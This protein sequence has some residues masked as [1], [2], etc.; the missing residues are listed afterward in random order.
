MRRL[1]RLTEDQIKHEAKL[2]NILHLI[3]DFYDL[4]DILNRQCYM[5]KRAATS[6]SWRAE[7]PTP[8]DRRP[9][10][11]RL[12]A[13]ATGSPSTT[14]VTHSTPCILHTCF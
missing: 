10:R 1:A 11:V 4:L 9:V 13:A 6:T 3:D 5:L 14:R 2:I 7:R 8:S 12:L